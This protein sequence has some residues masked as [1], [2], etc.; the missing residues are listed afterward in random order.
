M[1][2]DVIQRLVT[3]APERSNSASNTKHWQV[4]PGVYRTGTSPILV[5]RDARTA[6]ACGW[7]FV[8]LGVAGIVAIAS[9]LLLYR[10]PESRGLTS[11]AARS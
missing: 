8:S 10:R 1:A 7:A 11:A 3:S 5:W 6:A 4:N 9:A 2:G